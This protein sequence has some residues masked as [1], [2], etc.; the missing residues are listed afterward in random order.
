MKKIL[1]PL[2]TLMILLIGISSYLFFV[3]KQEINTRTLLEQENERL[4]S[5]NEELNNNLDNIVKQ[6]TSLNE[7]NKS[8][9]TQL[10]E[11]RKQQNELD[12]KVMRNAEKGQ[13]LEKIIAD[14]RND[15]RIKDDIISKLVPRTMT[16]DFKKGEELISLGETET[17]IQSLLGEGVE[18]QYWIDKGEGFW[19]LKGAHQ[20]KVKYG[21]IE[22]WYLK[23]EEES[24]FRA[25]MITIT[26][27]T[28]K[29][30]N[31]L[32]IGDSNER[33]LQLYPSFIDDHYNSDA[34][35]Y[36]YQDINSLMGLEIK[37]VNNKVVR[38]KVGKIFD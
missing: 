14:L 22:V 10:S 21:G 18:L 4:I 35:T 8:L 1:F 28:A 37:M 17:N 29:L 11:Y 32:T 9:E 33:V 34:Y 27:D 24:E 2:I 7:K 19:Y 20:K 6:N 31:G 23:Y 25:I 26:D 16:Y 30:T 36:Y 38:I 12:E 13:E 5:E 15:I 3:N